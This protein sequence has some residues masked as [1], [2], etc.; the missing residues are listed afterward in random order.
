MSTSPQVRPHSTI[1]SSQVPSRN[2]QNAVN[3]L[4]NLSGNKQ[5]VND[6]DRALDSLADSSKKMSREFESIVDNLDDI[7]SRST[8]IEKNYKDIV[9]VQKEIA[10]IGKLD[11]I[12]YK[13]MVATVAILNK[14]W[15]DLEKTAS[16]TK[17]YSAHKRG[18]EDINKKM[19]ELNSISEEAWD[20]DK[21]T[22]YL[23]GL[24]EVTRELDK[25]KFYTRQ[26]VSFGD[27]MANIGRAANKATGGTNKFFQ[28]FDKISATKA[29]L[30]DAQSY[31]HEKRKDR[32]LGAK[33]QRQAL[34][35]EENFLKNYKSTRG[36][37]SGMVDRKLIDMAGKGA[38]GNLLFNLARQ[39]GGSVISGIGSRVAG[40]AE[41]GLGSLMGI[42]SK[43]AGPMAIA[44]M[45]A[46]AY[47]ANIERNKKIQELAG[48][49]I[50]GKGANVGDVM[51][52]MRKTLGSTDYTQQ[53]MG[54]DFASNVD[55][56]KSLIYSGRSVGDITGKDLG[57][58]S[59]QGAAVGFYGATMKNA[60]YGG[61]PVGLSTDESVKLQ[62][63]LLDEYQST[64][65]E[66]TD[67]FK[68]I[69]TGT[70]AAGI[71]TSKY[72]EI[73]DSLNAGFDSM[74]KSLYTSVNLLG[75][76]SR[77]G[78][79]TGEKMKDV[80]TTVTGNQVQD[81]A[82]RMA[83]MQSLS[84][85][86]REDFVKGLRDD[87]AEQT[88]NMIANLHGVNVAPGETDLTKIE[89]AIEQAFKNKAIDQKTY[90]QYVENVSQAR[91][92]QRGQIGMA[93]ALEKGDYQTAAGLA[94]AQ[95]VGSKQGF[96]FTSGIAQLAA[97]STGI[98]AG[99]L[100][101][102]DV[103][104]NAAT[105]KAIMPVIMQ[106]QRAGVDAQKFIDASRTIVSTASRDV[107]QQAKGGTLDEDF[108]QRLI[109][110]LQD[111]GQLAKGTYTKE[112]AMGILSGATPLQNGRN[113]ADALSELPGIRTA[114]VS[115]PL[116]KLVDTMT[117]T[118][119][120]KQR[121]NIAQQTT[122]TAEAF[123]RSFEYLFTRVVDVLQS[124][125]NA[126]PF[127]GD[128]AAATAAGKINAQQAKEK[129]SGLLNRTD[130]S[131]QDR[132]R[133][134]GLLKS[135]ETNGQLS[136]EDLNTL[137]GLALKY[138]AV[139]KEDVAVAATPFQV[140]TQQPIVNAARQRLVE[141]GAN[142]TDT[143]I[144]FDTSGSWYNRWIS[145]PRR[146]NFLSAIETLRSSGVDVGQPV[147]TPNAGGGS[148]IQYNINTAQL[149][150][151]Q[152]PDAAARAGDGSNTASPT[153]GGA[154]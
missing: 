49:G 145:D 120:E 7:V 1:Q 82:Y 119:Q 151:L 107:M 139:K 34:G 66:T 110:E 27:A 123:A 19:T 72:L 87:A 96:M 127:T 29:R 105:N 33:E 2:L 81:T 80:L 144:S 69:N 115:G 60:I 10:R 41:G 140:A 125:L 122:T 68:Q 5:M 65:Q 99:D 39:G 36:G 45:M 103:T 67:F 153:T 42:G 23:N 93:E 136:A 63:K 15:Q 4:S 84:P 3:D 11:N 18:L 112:Q 74:N 12:S 28:V 17:F 94:M 46:Q 32:I 114:L 48:G 92:R 8:E 50:Y 106:L 124:I 154:R 43:L 118:E 88:K 40:M 56:M 22:E 44:G 37:F 16:N 71:S 137:S 142:I 108:A 85:K 64:L 101:S 152:N 77:T 128:K 26:A 111:S 76:L 117:D 134:E 126:L 55:T 149:A 6:L 130:L 75:S 143:G 131:P 54:Y 95:G 146:Q 141:A 53:L 113:I 61:T 97:R 79:L 62:M 90:Q 147:V 83:A 57:A 21:T 89:D 38:K 150:V 25:F 9:K 132:G 91:N 148:H 59:H 100:F 78:R 138:N 58:I 52:N 51:T 86:M 121:A 31:L 20:K 13:D 47:D 70:K 35:G 98:S 116:S 73:I 102:S 30:R 135:A 129:Y 24:K 14:K 104:K 133:V 109:K